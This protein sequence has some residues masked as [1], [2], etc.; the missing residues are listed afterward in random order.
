MRI[1]TSDGQFHI[2]A[3]ALSMENPFLMTVMNKAY[4][5]HKLSKQLNRMIYNQNMTVI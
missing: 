1:N 3:F 5:F 2:L 4:F